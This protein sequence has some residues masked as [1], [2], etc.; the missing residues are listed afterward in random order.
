MLIIA[1]ASA[2]ATVV[3]LQTDTYLGAGDNSFVQQIEIWPRQLVCSSLLVGGWFFI[4]TNQSSKTHA[5]GQTISRSSTTNY[6]A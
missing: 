5:L 3:N 6:T 2:E 4:R 1:A